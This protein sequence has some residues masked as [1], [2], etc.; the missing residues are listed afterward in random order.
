MSFLDSYRKKMQMPSADEALPGRTAPIP[1]SATHFVN[2]RP[3]KGP[4]PDGYK[5]V[6]FGM[7]CF[8]GA[9]RLFWQVPGVYVTA[10]GYAGG[11][12]PNPTYEETC[13]GLTGHA[14]VVLV[15]YDPKVV[16]LDELLTLFWEEHDPTQGMRQGN[17]IGT[18]YRSVI[19]T[20][21][22]ADRDMA[23]KSREAYAQA[24]AAR[25]IGPITTE[26]EDAPDFYYAED[27]H[28]Q[29]LAKNPNGYCGLRGTGVS[30][31]IPLAQ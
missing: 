24:L 29:Y 3:L 10:V 22:K 12:T 21:D 30:C 2:G 20:F 23:E 25:G 14:E 13:T 26:I 27:Y 15:V 16:S 5:Q 7:G 31:P 17:D 9:E 4:W 18:T 19:Y 28:Q 11:V 1:T 8:W 6:L